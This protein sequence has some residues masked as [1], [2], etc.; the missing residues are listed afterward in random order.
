MFMQIAFRVISRARIARRRRHLVHGELL[1]AATAAEFWTLPRVFAPFELYFNN[2]S[3]NIHNI[4]RPFLRCIPYVYR[5]NTLTG[6]IARVSSFSV[7]CFYSHFAISLKRSRRLRYL[8]NNIYIYTYINYD[9][10]S[11]NFCLPFPRVCYAFIADLID[12]ESKSRW[13]YLYIIIQKITLG[14]AYH[15]DWQRWW[16]LLLLWL[17]FIQYFYIKC[18]FFP[19]WF[20]CFHYTIYIISCG[21]PRKISPWREKSP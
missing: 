3:N 1:F 2:N 13:L 15:L 17:L 10:K 14:S 12:K 6:K 8:Y 9:I 11:R 18:S 4:Q 20:L 21:R 19:R 5:Y 7:Y 16:L